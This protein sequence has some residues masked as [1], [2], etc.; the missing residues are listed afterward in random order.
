M[1][2]AIT[3][4]GV[5]LAWE[6]DGEGTPI[7]FIHEFAGDHRS[8]EPQVRSLSRRYRCITYA[9]RGYAPSEVPEDLEAYSQER[10]VADAI[11]VLDDAG[12][13]ATDADIQ[14]RSSD[15]GDIIKVQVGDQPEETRSV[16][17]SAYAEAAGVDV[18]EVS[19][20]S[21]SSTWGREITE[22][23]V[24]AL[25]V[26]LALVAVF[27]SIRFEWRMALAS[28]ITMLHDV[29]LSVGIYSLFGFELTPETVIAF[30]TILGYSLYD[31]IVVFDRI[32][33][34]ERRLAS[35]SPPDLHNVSIN[36]VLLRSVN[37]SL[38]SVM[39][40][41]A[42]L[43]IGAGVLGVV[44]LREFSV[45]LLVGILVGAYSSIFVASPI[46]TWLKIRARG[47]RPMGTRLVGAELRDLVVSGSLAGR[48]GSVRSARRRAMTADPDPQPGD[49]VPAGVV[50]PTAPAAPAA[51][52]KRPDQLLSHAPRPRKKKRR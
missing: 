20:N 48:T 35:L 52:P 24:R 10:A 11:T 3:N 38:A 27:L 14:R 26:F 44:T 21:V 40:V 22:Q 31:T 34:N 2:V 8:W 19:V 15:S 49:P 9:A 4:D 47:S 43:I 33:E 41:I 29:L 42:L 16:L 37:T 17:Q 25:I 32:K 23:A 39:P 7:L 12:V 18:A 28:I 13:G 46:L 45:A 5:R 51:A 50:A 36:Q 30:L 6:E 1:S